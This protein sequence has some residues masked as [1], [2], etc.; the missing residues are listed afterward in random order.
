[1]SVTGFSE[2]TLQAREPHELARFYAEGFGMEVIDR[3]DDRVWLAAGERAR[4]GLWTP[5]RK[6]YGDEGGRHVHFALTVAPS[7]LEAVASRLR[8]LGTE[9]RGPV[10]HPG[11]TGRST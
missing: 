1:M 7:S 5:G 10:T 8:G 2:L 9:L 6:E 3:Q 11:A 4:L